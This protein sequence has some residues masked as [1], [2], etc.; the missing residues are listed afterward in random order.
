VTNWSLFESTT[1]TRAY[2]AFD[3]WEKDPVIANEG[4]LAENCINIKSDRKDK[5]ELEGIKDE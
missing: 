1:P 5:Q 4:E 2:L 3:R